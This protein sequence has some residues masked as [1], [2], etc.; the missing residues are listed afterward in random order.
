MLTVFHTQLVTS[1]I[2]DGLLAG[3]AQFGGCSPSLRSSAYRVFHGVTPANPDGTTQIDQVFVSPYG[4]FVGETKNMRGWIFTGDSRFKTKMPAN[5]TQGGGYVRYI[6][7]FHE[8]VCTDSEV[9][10]ICGR[11]SQ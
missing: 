8:R 4:V 9:K 11:L 1:A 5:V 10:A 7:Q 2:L 3:L 6:R